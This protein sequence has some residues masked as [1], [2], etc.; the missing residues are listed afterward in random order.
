MATKLAADLIKSFVMPYAG[1]Q[2]DTALMLRTGKS[3]VHIPQKGPNPTDEISL[4]TVTK[5]IVVS[6]ITIYPSRTQA[7]DANLNRLVFQIKD[8]TGAGIPLGTLALYNGGYT[9]GEAIQVAGANGM[10]KA[11]V[12]PAGG[13]ITVLCLTQGTGATIIPALTISVE[14]YFV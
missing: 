1:A 13:S 10:T 12:A 9:A 4:H 7:D 11:T 3:S 6:G 8:A 2:Q 5:P 14:Y